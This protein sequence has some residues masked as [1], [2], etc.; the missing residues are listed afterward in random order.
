[1]ALRRIIYTSQALE[2]FSKRDFLDMLHE[3]RAYN[4]IDNISGVL[5]YGNGTF[6]QII[7]GEQENVNDLFT[8]I[9]RDSRHKEVKLI[10][11]SFVDSR[12]FSNWAMGSAD[13][14]DPELSFIPG[15]RTD[16]SDPQVIEDII[17]H[18]PEIATFLLKN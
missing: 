9:L 3:S 11:D 8:R 4:S 12:Y 13:F 14:D 15:I 6:I 10:L 18:L 7:E 2:P 5:M 1:M 16:L 17:A